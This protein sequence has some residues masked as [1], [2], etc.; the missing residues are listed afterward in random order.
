MK[1]I[2]P[3]INFKKETFHSFEKDFFVEGCRLL[4]EQIEN[5]GLDTV[6]M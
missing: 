1:I 2:N 5:P 3:A 6:R 4:L